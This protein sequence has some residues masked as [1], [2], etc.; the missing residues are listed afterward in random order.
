[1]RL[2]A[3]VPDSQALVFAPKAPKYTVTVFTDVDCG[4]AVSFT[5]KIAQV[6]R[7]GHQSSLSVFPAQRPGD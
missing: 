3:A 7:A 6:Q 5:V 4:F 1:M 2:L